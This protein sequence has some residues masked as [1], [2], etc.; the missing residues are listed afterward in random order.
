VNLGKS[1][2]ADQECTSYAIK[3]K[4]TK[5]GKVYS[6]QNADLNGDF[7]KFSN[8]IT[9]SVKGK[10]EIMMLTPAGQISYLGIN[11]EGLSVNC[12]FLP[13]SG[14]K[15][16]FPRYLIS[17]WLL[18]ESTFDDACAKMEKLKER[19]ASR[20]ILLCDDKGN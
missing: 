17:R 11:K 16:G 5:H 3:E 12:N 1:G 14:W 15:K 19:A 18:E 8:V 4:C 13:C 9:F 20:N 7:E 6:G 10:P 2:A